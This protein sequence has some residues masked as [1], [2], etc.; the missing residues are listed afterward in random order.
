MKALAILVAHVRV[1]TS[2]GTRI[3]CAY[4]DS[5]GSGNV[6]DRDMSFCM[7]FAAAN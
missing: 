6:T 1:H 3:V 4:W 2:D 7:K 5:F